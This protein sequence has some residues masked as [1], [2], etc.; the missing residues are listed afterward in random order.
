MNGDD[1]KFACP[2]CTKKVCGY[3]P[4]GGDGSVLR[5]CRHKM[6]NSA[7]WCLGGESQ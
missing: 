5:T 6:P 4:K 7:L 3:V 2:R 1:E